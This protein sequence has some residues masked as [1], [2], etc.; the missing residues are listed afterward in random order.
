MQNIIEVIVNLGAGVLIG[1]IVTNWFNNFLEQNSENRR[2]TLPKSW[3]G[4]P[5]SQLRATK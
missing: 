4:T 1:G 5:S 2:R 3:N